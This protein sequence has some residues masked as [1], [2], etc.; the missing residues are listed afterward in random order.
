MAF[1]ICAV[2]RKPRETEE[3]FTTRMYSLRKAIE[4]EARIKLKLIFH[5]DNGKISW[6]EMRARKQKHPFIIK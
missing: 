5:F 6:A 3:V 2:E 4:E 1:F